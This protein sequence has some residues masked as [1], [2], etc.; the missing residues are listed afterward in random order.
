MDE[1]EPA[2][3]ALTRF[4]TSSRAAL[5]LGFGSLLMLMILIATSS[6]HALANIEASNVAIRQDFLQRDDL[7]DRLR[8]DLYRSSVDVRDYLL[9]TDPQLAE[10]R[11]AEVLKT[12]TE[13]TEA[14]LL[15]R[16][17]LPPGETAVVDELERDLL[18]YFR[19]VEPVLHWDAATRRR[20]GSD[21]IGG[22][23]LPRHEQLIG[24]AERMSAMDARQLGIGENSVAR[25]FAAFRK[26]VI[27]TAAMTILFGAALAFF[28]IGR[29]QALERESETRYRQVVQT[30]EELHRLSARIVDA[31]EEERRNLSRELHDE[32]GASMSA[33][34]IEL[35]NLDSALPAGDPALHERLQAVRRLAENNV[36]VLRNL[37]LLLRPSMLDDLGLIPALKW[38]ARE[39]ARRTG[40][41]IRVDADDVPDHLPDD[42]RTSIYRIVQEALNNAARHAKASQVRVTV[43]REAGQIRVVVQDDGSGFDPRHDKGMGIL[44]MEE[45]VRHLGGLFKI[46]SAPGRG[47]AVSLQLFDKRV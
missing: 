47:T 43:R 5:W 38:Q 11:R 26:E 13:M 40:M 25:V 22:Q 10:R 35:G 17:N 15:Y 28:S 18:A 31:Q 36:G 12:E 37:A 24:L 30:R 41:K 2:S 23:M 8:S 3:R 33:L 9:N 20:R 46:D 27:L 7:L 29:V 34:L 45:R 1:A 39:M 16:R 14:L 32:V 21:F 6:N 42:S 4:F 19:S 44:G